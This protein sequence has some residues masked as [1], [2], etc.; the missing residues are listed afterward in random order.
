MPPVIVLSNAAD[1][2]GWLGCPRGRHGSALAAIGIAGDEALALSVLFGLVLRQHICRGVLWLA[3]RSRPVTAAGG[4]TL[5]ANGAAGA[6]QAHE[7]DWRFASRRACVPAPTGWPRRER[8]IRRNQYFY[9]D[10]LSYMRFLVPTG[11]NVLDLGCGI[12]D[13]L[14][15]DRAGRGVGVDFS[16]PMVEIARQRHPGLEFHLGDIEDAEF[17]GSL[18]GPF[19]HIVMSDTIGSLEDCRAC[20]AIRPSSRHAS[21]PDRLLREPLRPD[22]AIAERLGQKMPS[23]AQN[24]MT[25]RRHRRTD[26]TGRVRGSRSRVAPAAAVAATRNRHARQSHAR[27]VAGRSSAVSAEVRGRSSAGPTEDA[28]QLG[29][30][31]QCHAATNAAT[32]RPP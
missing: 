16:L 28:H 26:A 6:H 20:L 21:R 2:V 4:K 31:I 14:A 22:I 32:L 25:V 30:F 24:F 1:L 15:F 10:D 17:V 3:G 8:W 5:S 18:D 23:E 27:D 19:D 7:P 11:S 12:G 29:V 9:D 13:L